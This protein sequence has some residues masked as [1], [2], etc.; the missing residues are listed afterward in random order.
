LPGVSALSQNVGINTT[1]PATQLHIRSDFEI[2]RMQGESPHLTFVAPDGGFRGYVMNYYDSWME[3]GTTGN[4]PI[5][6][7]PSQTT[8]ARF[9]PDGY[10]GIGIDNP[11]FRLDISGRI[12]IR[13]DGNTAG[14]WF[15]ASN[16]LS[17]PAFI[18]MNSDQHLGLYG[19]PIGWGVLTNT[20]TGNT[21]LGALPN[22]AKLGI[23]GGVGT[24]LE[25][26]GDIKVSGPVRPAFQLVV[27]AVNQSDFSDG[28]ATGVIIDNTLC[29]N[30]PNAMIMIMPVQFVQAVELKVEYDPLIA[31]WKIR[32]NVKFRLSGNTST[33]PMLVCGGGCT[34]LSN[35]G[36]ASRFFG[37]T[38]GD[39]FNVLII[40]Q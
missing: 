25:V 40:K 34:I 33:G 13:H 32:N 6:F 9:T 14:I 5:L 38:I 28:D 7:S 27:S 39:K 36:T 1:T 37:F 4:Y 3:I 29:N 22:T 17:T 26:S 2:I 8:V 18:G 12:R 19:D 31:K 15:G 16:L 11:L 20:A 10:L 30:D 24:A 21:R 23:V 35:Y